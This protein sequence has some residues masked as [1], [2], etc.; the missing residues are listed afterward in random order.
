[1]VLSAAL[2]AKTENKFCTLLNFYGMVF[3]FTPKG[4][5]KAF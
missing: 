5:Y 3:E 4:D 2:I 1:M